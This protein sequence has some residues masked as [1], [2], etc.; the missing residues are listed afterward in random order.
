MQYKKENY[1]QYKSITVLNT[2]EN[3]KDPQKCDN[4]LE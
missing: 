1:I 2:M 4:Y 3:A